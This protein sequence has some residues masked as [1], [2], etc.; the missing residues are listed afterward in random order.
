MTDLIGAIARE[1][2]LDLSEEQLAD[3]AAFL[4]RFH[5]E[6]ESLRSVQLAF[7]PPYIE[8]ATALD[9]IVNGGRS[10]SQS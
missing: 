7:L 2:R 1:R 10:E 3:A 4:E 6:L 8:P 9:W 5:N